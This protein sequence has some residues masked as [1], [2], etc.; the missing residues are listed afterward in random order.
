[1]SQK[2]YQEYENNKKINLNSIHIALGLNKVD[3]LEPSKY[4]YEALENSNTYQE[5]EDKLKK[6]YSIH[7]NSTKQREKECDIVSK[8]IAELID[9]DSFSFSPISL[10][11]IHKQLFSGAFANEL[12]IFVGVF[13]KVNIFKNEDIFNNKDSVTYAN[14]TEIEELL[15]Y[16]FIQEK[17]KNYALLN[18]QDKLTS[19]AQFISN[20][21]QIHPFREGNTRTIATFAIKYLKTK[22]IDTNNDIFK[23][24]AE[25]F[26]NALVLANY[27]NI[28]LKIGTDFSYL[29]SFFKTFLLD[30]NI[31]LKKMPKIL[32]QF[33][34]RALNLKEQ[35]KLETQI[36][37][38][39]KR[40]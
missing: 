19:I 38:T 3:K 28:K 30:K 22:G 34:D 18:P 10:K 11:S 24:N 1:M 31:A 23:E 40:R 6:H 36:R 37:K 14:H 9:D 21:W 29:E 26:R 7:K 12:E 32:P 13:R 4:F 35:E 25:Y 2:E 27:E 20:I 39:R 33:L 17:R 16:D 5:L 8:R 15:N